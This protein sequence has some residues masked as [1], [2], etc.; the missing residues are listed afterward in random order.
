VTE[1]LLDDDAAPRA[2]TLLDQPGL[3]EPPDDRRKRVGRRREIE[4]GVVGFVGRGEVA[5]RIA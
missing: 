1:R 2:L 5:E 4:D 3:A